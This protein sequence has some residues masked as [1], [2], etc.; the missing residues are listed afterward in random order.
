MSDLNHTMEVRAKG[1]NAKWKRV[2]RH[3]R[4]GK[5]YWYGTPY[6]ATLRRRKLL[7]GTILSSEIDEFRDWAQMKGLVARARV[8]E[9]TGDAIVRIAI[10]EIGVREIPPHSNRGPRVSQ[11]QRATNLWKT[12]KGGWPWCSAFVVWTAKQAGV[13]LPKD[14]RTASVWHFTQAARKHGM[15]VASPKP[16][17]AVV[18]FAEGRHIGIVESYDPKTRILHT[19]EGNTSSTGGSQ[20]NGGEVASQKRSLLQ[21]VYFIRMYR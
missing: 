17:D 9:S 3:K 14:M 18:L 8:A 6:A 1:S 16:G 19:I 20:V 21:A 2:G 15:I 12:L 4:T 11:Y 10:Q 5:F 13:N 7:R